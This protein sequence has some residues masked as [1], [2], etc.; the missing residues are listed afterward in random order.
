RCAKALEAGKGV[1]ALIILISY[2]DQINDIVFG[3]EGALK[4]LNKDAA[5]I[6]HSTISPVYIQKLE[7]SLAECH[8][9]ASVVDVYVSRG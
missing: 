3:Q 7:E 6:L 4:G 2:P 1:A 8:E 9:T 5:I